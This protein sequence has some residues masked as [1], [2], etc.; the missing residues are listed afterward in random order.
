MGAAA[1]LSAEDIF[2]L[3]SFPTPVSY[4]TFIPFSVAVPEPWGRVMKDVALTYG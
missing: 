2:S 4:S 1:L 3:Q